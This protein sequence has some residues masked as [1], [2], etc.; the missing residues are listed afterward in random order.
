MIN[1]LIYLPWKLQQQKPIW[2]QYNL[3][4]FYFYRKVISSLFATHFMHATG[5]IHI[6]FLLME[7]LSGTVH[8]GGITTE[9]LGIPFLNFAW[10]CWKQNAMKQMTFTNTSLLYKAAL[11]FLTSITNTYLKIALNSVK[12]F[13]HSI[14][15]FWFSNNEKSDEKTNLFWKKIWF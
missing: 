6:C 8:C 13:I 15:Y 1:I 5:Q 4:A 10:W 7:F 12:F 11:P 14:I 2:I 9:R 3:T